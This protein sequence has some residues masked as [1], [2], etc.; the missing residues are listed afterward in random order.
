M[1]LAGSAGYAGSTTINAGTL[2][3]TGAGSIAASSGVVNKGTFDISGTASGAKINAVGGS[4][5]V[6][7]GGRTLTLANAVGTFSGPSG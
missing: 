4:G 2:E 7:V 3:L 6:G 5:S 1:T